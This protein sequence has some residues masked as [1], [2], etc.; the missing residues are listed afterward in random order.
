[1]A[2]RARKDKLPST[3]EETIERARRENDPRLDLSG[4]NLTEVPQQVFDLPFLTELN[5]AGNQLTGLPD[6]LSKL[7]KLQSLNLQSNPLREIPDSVFSIPALTSL[8]VSYTGISRISP[9]I[10]YLQFL[11]TL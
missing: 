6:S 1:M 10:R 8:D 3:A 2:R 4:T 11:R 9:D 7:S 5:L